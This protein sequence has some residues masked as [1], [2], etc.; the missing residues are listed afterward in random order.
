MLEG[1]GRKDLC[2]AGNQPGSGGEEEEIPLRCLG[3]FFQE[4]GR[5]ICSVTWVCR[6]A[7]SVVQYQFFV[8]SKYTSIMIGGCGGKGEAC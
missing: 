8:R 3:I 7:H 1:M 4:V 6:F 5:E 2:N